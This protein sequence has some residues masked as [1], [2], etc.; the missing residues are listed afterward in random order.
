MLLEHHT[1]KI[2]NHR[3]GAFFICVAMDHYNPT[4]AVSLNKTY[5]VTTYWKVKNIIFCSPYW[6]LY[7]TKKSK[8][9]CLFFRL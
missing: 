3:Q 6:I 9:Y 5:G 7:K 8:R 2:F 4:E 1:K